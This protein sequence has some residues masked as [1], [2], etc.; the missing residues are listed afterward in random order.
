MSDLMILEKTI[1]EQNGLYCLNDLHR[2]SGGQKRHKVGNWLNNQQTIEFI[3][4]ISKSGN[5]VLEQNQQVIHVVH[6]GHSRGTY[7]CKKLAY[8]YAMWISPKFYSD[9]LDVFDGVV[10]GSL[11]VAAPQD[12]PP[13]FTPSHFPVPPRNQAEA[14]ALFRQMDDYQQHVY[15]QY[16]QAL[17]ARNRLQEL[18]LH[19]QSWRDYWQMVD[20]LG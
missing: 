19:T 7:A 2:A 18:L 6:G 16:N 17:L 4:Y 5:P 13:A 15:Q 14:R 9:V 1:R 20:A 12:L 11:K 3:D 8:H 10:S